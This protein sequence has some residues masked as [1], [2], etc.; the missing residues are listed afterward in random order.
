VRET[1]TYGFKRS[2]YPGPYLE[3]R[4]WVRDVL[5]HFDRVI[6]RFNAAQPPV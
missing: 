2:F 4:A 3:K 5:R 1:V 6:A